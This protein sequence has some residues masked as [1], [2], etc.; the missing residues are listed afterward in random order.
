MSM[1]YECQEC[2]KLQSALSENGNCI[3]CEMKA[4]QVKMRDAQIKVKLI[5]CDGDVRL[6]SKLTREKPEYIE[7]LKGKMEIKLFETVYY[8]C[9]A[10]GRQTDVILSRMGR[11]GICQTCADRLERGHNLIDRE[12]KYKEPINHFSATDITPRHDEEKPRTK[13]G[14][15][16][17]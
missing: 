8:S 16:K 10:C 5:E 11:S 4:R 17:K 15:N 2:K 14:K 13:Q 6:V 3:E 12:D 7:E 9:T 1:V